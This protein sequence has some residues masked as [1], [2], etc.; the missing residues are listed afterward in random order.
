MIDERCAYLALTQVPGVGHTRLQSLLRACQ[1]SVGAH[2]A[3]FAFL[4]SVPGITAACASAIKRTPLD[5]GRRLAE[6]VARLGGHVLIPADAE[7]PSLLREIPDP[8]P[9]LFALGDLGLLARP[10][11]AI[12]GSRDH[13]V[14][15]ES[16]ARMVSA[17][18]ARAGLVVVSGMA[19]GL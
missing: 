13:T 3:P 1:T 5:T 14:Y 12:V 16:V 7:F 17:K 9:V 2:A 15:G 4:C 19:R 11:V 6:E 10:A 18:A 8:P